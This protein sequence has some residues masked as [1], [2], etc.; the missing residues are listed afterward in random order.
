MNELYGIIKQVIESKDYKLSEIT[1]RIE[2][3]CFEGRISE[4][5]RDELIAMANQNASAEKEKAPTQTQLDAIF[6][7]LGEIG[8][9]LKVLTERV[10]ELEGTKSEGGESEGDVST[11]ET[12]EYPEW[13]R[14]NGI[15]KIP[16]QEGSKCTHNGVKYIS[17][18]DNNFWEPGAPGV[19]EN[20]WKKV[21][22]E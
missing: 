4:E 6:E 11:E 9:A 5:E 20:I 12:E 17:M 2:K 10:V 8:Q 14:W 7:N 1:G 3:R 16:Y 18:V 21:E 13:Q 15:D 22:T 19:Y